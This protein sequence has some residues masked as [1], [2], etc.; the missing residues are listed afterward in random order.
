VHDCQSGGSGRACPRLA[1]A[2]TD[3]AVEKVCSA[4]VAQTTSRHGW[5]IGCTP[6]RTEALRTRAVARAD[7]VARCSIGCTPRLHG[8]D[9]FALGCCARGRGCEFRL[10]GAGEYS[11]GSSTAV[12]TVQ[13][14]APRACCALCAQCTVAR[15]ID[16]SC[17]RCTQWAQQP[18]RTRYSRRDC[19][20]VPIGRCYAP[21]AFSRLVVHTWATL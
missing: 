8:C 1:I 16:Y 15:W 2:Q 17:T 21:R 20:E 5:P 4:D 12:C 19:I 13:P 18:R 3:S 11:F 10:H 14:V 6:Q 7:G 9:W